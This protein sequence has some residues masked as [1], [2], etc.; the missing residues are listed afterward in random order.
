MLC[1]FIEK[2]LV[3]SFY[4]AQDNFKKSRHMRRAFGDKTELLARKGIYRYEWFD[5]MDI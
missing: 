3:A 4:E 5:S 1:M 2:K